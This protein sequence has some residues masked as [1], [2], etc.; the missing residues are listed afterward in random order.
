M[1]KNKCYTCSIR[2]TRANEKKIVSK[3]TYVEFPKNSH[4]L[5]KSQLWLPMY[6]N[7]LKR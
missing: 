1:I 4:M 6:D 5:K 3:L 2:Q 7:K